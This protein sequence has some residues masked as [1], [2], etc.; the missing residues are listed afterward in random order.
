[1][2]GKIVTLCRKVEEKTSKEGTKRKADDGAGELQRKQ[3]RG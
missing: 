2:E 3:A 1:M